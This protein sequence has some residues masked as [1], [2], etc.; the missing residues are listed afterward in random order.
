MLLATLSPTLPSSAGPSSYGARLTSRVQLL[1][2]ST[3]HAHQAIEAVP[4]M[5]RLLAPDYSL[6]EYRLLLARLLGYI[7][8][9]EMH[10]AACPDTRFQLAS[11]RSPKLRSDLAELGVPRPERSASPPSFT[12]L[13]FQDA[14]THAGIAYV[15]EGAT[16]GGQVI[17]RALTAHL[18]QVVSHAVSYFDC[19]NGDQGRFWRRTIQQIDHA[20]D[21]DNARMAD[22]A[23]LIF[24]S[25]SEWLTQR[26]SPELRAAPA[27]LA[28]CPFAHAGAQLV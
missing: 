27:A 1:R 7:E 8:P 10:L 13:D 14:S 19:Y 26:A 22:A 18:G 16:L 9:L 5:R 4:C 20:P 15:F 2:Q 21:L 23:K 3:S 28:R 24:S 6:S 25:L 12:G 17:R 11:P